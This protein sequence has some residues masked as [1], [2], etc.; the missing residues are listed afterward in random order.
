MKNDRFWLAIVALVTYEKDVRHR[1]ALACQILEPM[2]QNELPKDLWDRLEVVKKEA[3]KKGV[4]SNSNSEVIKDRYENTIILRH[5]KT[6][7]K[8]AKEIFS[9]YEEFNN[10]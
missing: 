4:L 3:G 6:Y 2:R 9:I 8:L 7:S 1:V 10:N 5:N